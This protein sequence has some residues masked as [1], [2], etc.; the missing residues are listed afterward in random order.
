MNAVERRLAR[1]AARNAAAR[2]E[3][4]TAIKEARNAG[5]PLRAISA[6]AGLSPEWV[7]RIAEGTAR[8]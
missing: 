8:R 6:Q 1:A 4:E 2:A 5:M 7:R 3:L